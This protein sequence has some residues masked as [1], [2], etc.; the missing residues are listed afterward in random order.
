MLP[1]P[2]I[3]LEHDLKPREGEEQKL[4]SAALHDTRLDLPNHV[5]EGSDDAGEVCQKSAHAIGFPWIVFAVETGDVEALN[6]CTVEARRK[7][8]WPP[9]G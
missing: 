6:L 9:Q 8:K 3:T 2:P 5:A 1:P 7:A 4:H